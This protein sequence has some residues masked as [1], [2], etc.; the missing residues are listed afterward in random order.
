MTYIELL[1]DSVESYSRGNLSLVPVPDDLRV[2]QASV[3]ALAYD[4]QES[5]A[6]N[7]SARSAF[8]RSAAR[9]STR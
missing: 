9:T 1:N 7:N 3:V 5:I 8:E 4:M 2:S 6:H